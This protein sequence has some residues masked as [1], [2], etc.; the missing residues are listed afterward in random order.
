MTALFS[1]Q[2]CHPQHESALF[3]LQLQTAVT[4]WM[5]CPGPLLLAETSNLD[6]DHNQAI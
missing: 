4:W 2:R 3:L 1:A 6:L 5:I